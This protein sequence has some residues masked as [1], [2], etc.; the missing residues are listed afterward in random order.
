MTQDLKVLQSL[1]FEALAEEE[2]KNAYSKRYRGFVLFVAKADNGTVWGSVVVN[3]LEI[4]L[5]QIPSID[6]LL[7]FDEENSTDTK[8]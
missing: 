8:S 3:R 4:C 5:P 6:W 1:G 7:E 2:A